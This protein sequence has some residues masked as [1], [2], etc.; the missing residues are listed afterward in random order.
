MTEQATRASVPE[1]SKTVVESTLRQALTHAAARQDKHGSWAGDQHLLLLR[2]APQ[3]RG[4]A[5]VTIEH[6]G[7]Q[8][9]ADVRGCGTVLAV[10]AAISEPRAAQT[11]LVVLTPC[12]GRE[13]G[14]SVLARALGGEVRPIHRWDL[15][16]DAFGARKLD[17]RLTG[18]QFRWLA[19]ALLDAQPGAGWRR[20]T[21]SVLQ[22][23]AALQRLAAVRLGRGGEDER[24]DAAALLDWSR[25]EI[26]LARFLALRQEEQDGLADWLQE[27]VGPVAQIVFRLL[28]T[29]QVTDAIPFGLA[30]A[31]FCAK[32]G[33]GQAVAAARIRAEERFLGGQAPSEASLR[34]F[35]EAAESL[36]LRWSENGH[37]GDAQAMCDRAEQ[38]LRELGAGDLPGDSKILDAG[39]EA[40]ITALADQIALALP[41]PRP[42]DLT[43]AETALERLR[44]HR[45]CGARAAD[46]AAG[47]A[48][49]QLARWLAGTDLAPATVSDGVLRH[50]RCWAWVDRALA[51]IWNVDTTKTP[52]VRSGYASLFDAVSERRADMDRAFAERLATWSPVA[53]PTDDL[54][55]AENLLERIGRPLA[56]RRAP[57]VI[58]VDGMSAAV[59]CE[60]TEEI[61]A[62]GIWTEVGR[63]A[64][65]REGALAVLPSATTF[66]RTSLLCGQLRSG[67]QPQERAGFAAFWQGRKAVL[68][69]KGGL[70]AGAGAVLNEDV[71]TAITNSAAVVGIVLNTIDDA[72]RD[73]REGSAPTWWLRDVTYL[74]ELLSAAAGAGRPVILT[75]DHGHVIDRG[76]GIHPATSES[77]RYRQGQ[78][79]DGEVLVSGPRVLSAGGTAVLPWDERIRYTPRKAG[80]HGGASLA[81]M[82]IPVLA[83]VPSATPCPKGWTSYDNPALH[84]PTW[85]NAGATAAQP[86][87]A[88]HPQVDQAPPTGQAPSAR[89]PAKR[90]PAQEEALFSAGEVSGEIAGQASLGARVVGSDRFAAQRGFVRKA[91][92]DAAVAAIIDGLT[93]A[94]GK[95]PV[96]VAAGLAGQPAFRMAGYLAQLGRLLNVDGYPVISDTDSGRTVELN[97]RLLT[98]QFLGT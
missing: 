72:L 5:A 82:I 6:G 32:D 24:L 85:W 31:E 8:V 28:Q 66:S 42:V 29:G 9:T 61:T 1:A 2:A 96:G 81:E 45:R 93:E 27:S 87:A 91:P 40:R 4:P 52:R 68:F 97:V 15:V 53:G 74:Q 12:D 60:L 18:R 3:W 92:A 65:G 20:V 30:A 73:G 37:A 23:D 47:V 36:T 94:G 55:L 80:Y 49:L 79:G 67:S 75:S 62:R 34:I 98:E 22:F 43:A 90:A 88:V 10:L 89:R 76:E 46:V 84:E 14:N 25:D 11:Y 16:A 83:F 78:P 26:R 86:Q 95:L 56:E 58:V 54:L 51:V 63:R 70:A 17:P 13:L 77:A 7:G 57:L 64:D 44:E 39:V 50:I 21:G 69:H 35:G 59:A 41:A 48:A 71:H 19:E 38:I 33:G